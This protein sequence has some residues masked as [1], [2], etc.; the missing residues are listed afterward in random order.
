[1]KTE[2]EAKEEVDWSL[3]ITIYF[4]FAL[5]FFAMVRDALQMTFSHVVSPRIH[6]SLRGS[7]KATNLATGQ[8]QK[9]P[10]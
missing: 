10:K 7:T 9:R 4:G 5:M 1:M 6:L 2:E 3:Y 8:G